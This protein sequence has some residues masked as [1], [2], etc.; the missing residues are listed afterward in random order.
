[1]DTDSCSFSKQ[2]GSE[3]THDEQMT[4]IDEINDTLPEMIKFSHDGYLTHLLIVRTKNYA[5]VEDGKKTIRGASL[6]ATSKEPALKAFIIEAIDMLLFEDS[7]DIHSLY[8]KY[9][10]KILALDSIDDWC[11]KR[12]IT[13][14]VFE[15]ERANETKIVDA[16]RGKEFSIGDKIYI[17]FRPDGTLGLKSEWTGD[18]DQSRLLSKLYATMKTFDTVVDAA[19]FI[20][21][22]L[23]TKR[24]FLEAI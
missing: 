14:K 22:S 8:V 13:N 3:F 2:D 19:P 15:S 6:R 1:V 18:H 12:S 21:Y 7:P 24:K 11:S 5:Y 4:C 9:V 10:K 17:Y 16:I 23:K 20:N